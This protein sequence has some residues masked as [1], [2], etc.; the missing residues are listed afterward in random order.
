MRPRTLLLLLM[1]PM[2]IN[3][4]EPSPS[5]GQV[6]KQLTYQQKVL[7]MNGFQQGFES[8]SQRAQMTEDDKHGVKSAPG[9]WMLVYNDPNGISTETLVDGVSKCYEDF[10]NADLAS[11]YCVDWTVQGIRG[12]SDTAR[13]DYMTGVRRAAH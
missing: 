7:Y 3:A 5:V 10:R 1:A 4:Q 12:V 6:W 9:H 8:G 2:L 13:E 11:Q